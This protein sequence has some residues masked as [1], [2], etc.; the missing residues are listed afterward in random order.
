MTLSAVATRYAN[1]LADVVTVRGSSLAPETALAELSAFEST[2]RESHE[3]AAALET[4]AIA[5]SRKKAVVGRIVDKL[6]LSPVTRNFL[7]VLT[8][9]RRMGSLSEMI[10]AFRTVLDERTGI[11]PAEIA[12]AGEMNEAER[13]ALANEL[14]KLTGKRIRMTFAVDRSLIGGVVAKVGSTLYDGS[15]RGSLESLQRRLSAE[16]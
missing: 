9:R 8:D 10:H 2:I 3:L 1:A 16:G 11:L 4:P 7:F 13:A 6:Q 12:S 5:A 15:V 14:E